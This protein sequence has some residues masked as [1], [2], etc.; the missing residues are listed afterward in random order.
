VVTP[1]AATTAT[2]RWRSSTAATPGVVERRPV[3]VHRVVRG[4][5]A[6]ELGAEGRAVRA[7]RHA[8]DD[9]R[10]ATARPGLRGEGLGHRPRGLPSAGAH[11]HDRARVG[12]A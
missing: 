10:A 4:L 12:G 11:H 9:R 8:A 1:S 5:R 2:A 3:E 6:L 7:A